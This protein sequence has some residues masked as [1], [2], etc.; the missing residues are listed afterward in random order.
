[1]QHTTKMTYGSVVFRN[2]LAILR[3][4]A[5]GPERQ[6]VP[7]LRGSRKFSTCP[8]VCTPGSIQSRRCAATS[9]AWL[10][11]GR[12]QAHRLASQ[13]GLVPLT[14]HTLVVQGESL[15]LRV[16]YVCRIIAVQ[17]S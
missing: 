9:C 10:A 16:F 3:F 12:H 17:V 13:P 14:R 4:G 5:V 6:D 8:G 15:T 1:M 2:K 11:I 7:P